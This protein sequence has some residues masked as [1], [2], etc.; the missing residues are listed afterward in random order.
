LTVKAPGDH[1][2]ATCVISAKQDERFKI[3]PIHYSGALQRENY[4]KDMWEDYYNGQTSTV[5]HLV[6]DDAGL[7]EGFASMASVSY[8]TAVGPRMVKRAIAFASLYG[9]T[10]YGV[11]CSA[12]ESAYGRWHDQ[13]M[14]FVKA[15]DFK[16]TTNNA[17]SGYY[18][19]FIEDGSLLIKGQ[20]FLD[21]TYH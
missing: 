6:K 3:Y 15:V 5:Y 2:Y 16:R 11:E 1:D 13:F 12:E 4:S 20:N 8:E 21:D 17:L 7:D 14:S 19:D 10:L 9:N 18:R